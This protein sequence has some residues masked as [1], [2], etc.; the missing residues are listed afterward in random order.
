M[1]VTQQASK[2]IYAGDGARVEFFVP[3]VFYEAADLVVLKV[4]G[5]GS[6]QTQKL[7]VDYSVYGGGQNGAVTMAAAPDSHERLVILRDI[8]FE[9]PI[10]YRAND[11]FPAETHE[12]GLDR[13]TLLCQQLEERLSR[14]FALSRGSASDATLPAV[15]AGAFI[16]WN[17][18][19]DG[20]E[21]KTITLPEEALIA[22]SGVAIVNNELS[23]DMAPDAG[24]DFVAGELAVKVDGSTIR[25]GANGALELVA[26]QSP[27]RTGDVKITTQ[28][29]AESGWLF[30]NGDS[31]GNAASSAAH[32]GDQFQ[33]LY[34]HLWTVMANQWAPVAGGRGG[35]ALQDWIDGKALTLSAAAG[36][37]LIGQGTATGFTDRAMGATGGEETH[38]LTSAEMP[39]HRHVMVGK[40]DASS[41]QGSRPAFGAYSVGSNRNANTEY[42]GSSGA[43]NNMPPFL[44]LNV[45]IKI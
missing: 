17:A 4:A 1:T 28:V 41:N 27:W 18:A 23:I 6:E 39:R 20:L 5:D 11:P 22:G 14:T 12:R 21:N 42:T 31:L 35:T 3:F 16:G 32:A 37:A 30:M 40:R 19:G 36:R 7:D 24:L 29:S 10:D 13:L 15:T 8:A 33:S 45:M 44:A 25:H 43:H 2:V 9:Q 26:V 34:T 38:T